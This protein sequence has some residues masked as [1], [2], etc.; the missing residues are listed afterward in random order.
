[1]DLDDF[2]RVGQALINENDEVSVKPSSDS[3]EKALKYLDTRWYTLT[4]RRGRWMDLIGDYAGS[5]LF[6]IDGDALF[7]EV[8]NDP[9]LALGRADEPSFQVL[10]AIYSLERR[11]SEFKNRSATFEIAFWNENRHLTLQTGNTEFV[12]M[13]RDLARVLLFKHL[14]RLDISVHT[15]KSLTDPEWRRY[16]RVHKPMFIMT[17]DGGMLDANSPRLAAERILTQRTFIFDVLAQGVSVSLL[18]G[19]EYRDSK[20]GIMTFVYEQRL[21]HD[22]RKHFEN[23][24]WNASS[25]ALRSLTVKESQAWRGCSAMPLD[26][27]APQGLQSLTSQDA[28]LQT[29]A[30]RVIDLTNHRLE[31]MEE[32]LFA[33]I[34]HLLLLPMLS[35]AE[36]ARPLPDLHPG[37]V[38]MLLEDFLPS[39]FLVLKGLSDEVALDVDG[40]VF[41]ALVD[42]M[43]KHTDASRQD[44]FG[45]ET[46]V[47]LDSIWASLQLRP[48]DFAELAPQHPSKPAESSVVTAKKSKKDR[49]KAA[50]QR[51]PFRLLP[52]SHPVFD[53]ELAEVHVDVDDSAPDAVQAHH[54]DFNTIFNDVNHWHNHRRAVLPPHLGG[55]VARPLDERQRRRKLRSDQRFMAS[56]EWQAQ[57][58]TG[59]FGVPLE[60]IVI[61]SAKSNDPQPSKNTKTRLIQVHREPPKAKPG[62]KGKPAHVSSAD[63]IRQANLA[64]KQ[65]KEDDSNTS[66][67][68]EQLESL[69]DGSRTH[70]IFVADS[71]LRNKRTK[72]TWLA[73]EVRLYRLHLEFLRW[74]EHPSR[75]EPSVRDA[76]VVAI[77]RIVKDAYQQ[78]ELFEAAVDILD[79]VL[80][81][82]GLEMA[83]EELKAAAS[84][85]PESEDRAPSFKF[86]KLVKSKSGS[87]LHKFMHINEDPFVW[88]LR[89]FGE[90]MDRSMDS[91]SDPRVSFQPDAWQR[92]VLDALD[93]NQSV[94]AVAPTSAGKTF[95]SYYA[96]EQI[97]RQTNDGILVYVAPT[98]ALVN[99]IAAEVHARFRK[100]L[101]GRSCWAIHTRDYRIHDPQNCQILV[102]VPEMLAIML[103]SPPLARVWTPRIKRVILDEIHTIGQQE[104]G[105]V[106]EQILLLAPCPIIGLS[107]TIGHPEKF[108]AWL[109]SVQQAHGF[110]HTFIHHPHRYSH[111]RKFTYILQGKKPPAFS[112]LSKYQHTERL[113]FLHPISLLSFGA[114]ELPPDFSLEAADCLSLFNALRDH[115]DSSYDIEAL[116]P[117]R[118]FSS[119]PVKLLRQKDILKYEDALKAVVSSLLT[120]VNSPESPSV[121][122]DVVLHLTDPLLKQGNHD[123]VPAKDDFYENVIYLV[124]DLH[125]RGDLPALLFNFD[126]KACEKMAQSILDVLEN[127]E[128]E[129]RAQSPEWQAKLKQWERWK[130]QAKNRER[131]LERQLRQ[132]QGEDEPRAPDS[133]ASWESTFDPS[134]PLS[135]YSFA[136]IS[137]AY[138]MNDLEDEIRQ[139]QRWSSVPDWAFRALR[140]G[141]GVHHA[142]MNKRYRSLVE[143][144]Y[145]M[146]FLRVVVATGTLALGIN[147]PTRTSVFCGDSPFLTALMYRQCAG[148]AGRRGFDLLGKVVFYGIALDRCRRLVLS[149]LPSLGGNFPLTSTMV[150]RLFNLLQGSENAPVA[151]HAIKALLR[152]PHVG[153]T[154]DVGRQHML[155]FLRFSIDYLRRAGLMD[156]AGNPINLFG[157]AAHLYYTEPGNLALIAL[158]RYGVIHS[159][160]AQPNQFA[161]R[162]EFMVLMCHIFSRRYLPQVYATDENL[163][164][165]VKKSPSIVIL[166]PLSAKAKKVLKEHDAE[167]LYVFIGYA[168]AYV[169]QHQE[170]LGPDVQL[171]FSKGMAGSELK[172]SGL[173]REYLETTAVRVTARSSFVANSGHGDNF[174][175]VEELA[176][177]ARHGLNLNQ[178]AIPSAA[179]FAAD[180]DDVEGFYALNAYLLDFYTHGQPAALKAANGIRDNDVWYLLEDFTLTLKTVR[181]GLEQ[182]LIKASEATM[183]ST[184]DGIKNADVDS[185]YGTLD[186]TE[187]DEDEDGPVTTIKR[188]PG[189]KDRDWKVYEVVDAVTKEF[190]EKFRAMWA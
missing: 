170:Q 142:G 6:L 8:L 118:F 176:R 18:H 102:T 93:K 164:Y 129:W 174:H 171:P 80:R 184:D 55:E 169:E 152:L 94:L 69:K 47:R 155:H 159:I 144:L 36:R 158:L 85:A 187:V 5:E 90:Y 99:Q 104:G 78:R 83:I 98:K 190:D 63:K 172:S 114:T 116:D 147:A 146:G 76:A 84:I 65:L 135:H 180:A 48:V 121:I 154:S 103:L 167:I 14:K 105:A 186:P 56:M 70:Q 96:M 38:N 11:L 60:R 136:S 61:T 73:V 86:V 57:T 182:L 16:H 72:S 58:L 177:T 127:A 108:N 51:K 119:C 42:Y 10:H 113:K 44:V 45:E 133:P 157:V 25:A 128:E 150:L 179:H 143:S 173:F 91:K 140:R 183:G 165:L 139:L 79:M 125:S 62:K 23:W 3:C 160:C 20:A 175:T 111:L 66:W 71:L 106:W 137:T 53:E 126:R 109:S 161:A 28:L 7:Q 87:P 31:C 162:R 82:V 74:I 178:Y 156:K 117:T 166:P 17:N 40:R 35:V 22:A 15:F 123:S 115:C 39:I 124:S 168:V 130:A 100:D 34:A 41:V 54:L 46:S 145:R 89:L 12:F 148:R 13:S 37:L 185:G 97:L 81:V 33:F 149:R 134:E 92:D 141:V 75:E 112:G 151:V 88:Q 26:A 189:V 24:L 67:W 181:A 52:F 27:L 64:K 110:E 30:Q 132:K 50:S 9:L 49:R 101:N 163:Q 77:L 131:Q 32:L 153:F 2:E 95:I 68:K 122:N 1:M 19:A 59:A 107:A 120:S 29:F 188:P 21:D 138:S 43:Q 4:N